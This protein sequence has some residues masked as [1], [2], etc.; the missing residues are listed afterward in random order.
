MKTTNFFAELQR[1]NVYRVAVAYGV[2]SWLLVQIATQVFP[3]FDIPNWATRLVV[4]V[5]LLG[6]PI[7][8]VFAWIFELTPEGIKRTDEIDPRHSVV[9]RT[10]RKLDFII[11]GILLVVIAFFAVNS[12]RPKRAP[13]LLDGVAKSIAVLPFENLSADPENAFFAS[14]VQDEILLN[15]SK[16]ADLKVISRTSVMQYKAG[17]ERSMHES[18]KQL[19]VSHILEGSVERVGSRVR[20]RAQLIDARSDN[21]VWA[22]QYDRDV[23]DVFA[24]QTEIAKA[25][26]DQLEAKLSPTE[27]AAIEKP[28][29]TDLVAYDKYLRA[30]ELFADTSDPVHAREKLPRAARLLDEAVALDPKFLQAWCLLS[31]VHGAAYFRG[32]DP[33]PARLQMAKAAVDEALRLQPDAGEAHLAFAIFYYNGFRNYEKAREELAIARRTLP[34]NP[35]VLTYSGFV[36]RREGRW[37]EATRNLE[38]ALQLDPRNFFT[39]QQLALTYQPQRRYAD[40]LR[41]YDRAL[42]IEPEDPNTLMLR[43]QVA[44]DERADIEPYRAALTNLL[45]RDPSIGRDIDIPLYSLCERTD[46]AAAR[47]LKNFPAEGVANNGVNYPHSYWEGVIARWQR[48]D[49][50]SQ[51][52]FLAAR[53]EVQALIDKQ[54]QF[55]AALSLLGL[56]DAGLGRKAE[57]IAEGERACRLLPMS[58]DAVDGAVLAINLAQIYAWTG[59]V[60]RALNQIATVERAPNTLSYGLLRLQPVWDPLRSDPRFE[61][62]VASLAPK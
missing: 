48:D 8:L 21:H 30:E 12:F 40:T 61:K 50:H 18:A 47:V 4:V 46:A 16:V 6:F 51:Q 2:V 22:E 25:I 36:D 44:V 56:I 5:L 37:G 24:I 11:I 23:A 52:A 3:F 9:R 1:R 58:R 33:T 19:G 55:A 14:G 7:A 42:A 28:P 10:G 59:E 35:E 34:N 43:A 45:A 32:H 29:T 15:L 60:D 39:M 49:A 20:L 27:K 62:L 53:K 54:P 17:A 13:V 26:V 57:A 31:R 38:R 41:T